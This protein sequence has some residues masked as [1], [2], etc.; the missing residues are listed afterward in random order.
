MS[1]PAFVAAILGIAI[2]ASGVLLAFGHLSLKAI[3]ALVAVWVGGA[4]G[5][6]ACAL[7]TV[8]RDGDV[9]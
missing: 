8:G 7:M 5:Y 3:V 6:F 4:I 2:A 9:G 1:A